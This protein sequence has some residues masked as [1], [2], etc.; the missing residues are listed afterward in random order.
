[1][2]TTGYKG[3]TNV[4]SK[5]YKQTNN[6]RQNL[7]HSSQKITS[8]GFIPLITLKRTNAEGSLTPVTGSAVSHISQ[9]IATTLGKFK[10][11]DLTRD[12]LI[13]I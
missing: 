13:H 8:F 7:S 2:S 4:S 5:T 9:S 3:E 6:Y 11:D 12:I 1:M 10:D